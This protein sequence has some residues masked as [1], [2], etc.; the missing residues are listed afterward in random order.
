LFGAGIRVQIS[1]TFNDF[2]TDTDFQD[3][4]SKRLPCIYSNK[5][6]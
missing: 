4:S 6:G 3:V 5:K 2:A 1:T